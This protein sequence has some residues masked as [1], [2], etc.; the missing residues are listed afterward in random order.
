MKKKKLRLRKW[1]RVT[2]NTILGVV[3]ATAA[4]YALACAVLQ[5]SYKLDPPS[6]AEVQEAREEGGAFAWVTLA[7]Y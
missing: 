2:L 7:K 5:T 3:L 1:V 6:A 4:M